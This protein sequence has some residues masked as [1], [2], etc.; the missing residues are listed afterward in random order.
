MKLGT[1]HLPANSNSYFFND[2]EGCPY[3]ESCREKAYL[4][5]ADKI[6]IAKN[7]DG[8]SCV[9]YHA[10]RRA[11]VGWMLSSN[12]REIAE[13][14][15][16]DIN[17]W[18]GTWNHYAAD[19]HITISPLQGNKLKIDGLAFWYGRPGI[20]HDGGIDGYGL[21]SGNT[22]QASEVESEYACKIK[23]KLLGQYLIAY[24]NS[25]CGGMN[26]RFN[27]VYTKTAP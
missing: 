15:T 21:V 12:I 23:M 17:A 6:L 24:D 25:S 7:Q 5:S 22:L 19:G 1:V 4:I 16:P 3:Q 10:K 8:W 2:S 20:V 18:F 27:N 11:Y 26:V 13:I 9:W 14:H